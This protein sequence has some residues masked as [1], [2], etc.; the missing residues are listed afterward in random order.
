[1]TLIEQGHEDIDSQIKIWDLQRRSYLIMYYAR[2]KGY[3]NLGLQ[4]LPVLAASEYNGKNAI[5]MTMLLTDIKKS[6]YG[7]EKWTLGETSVETVLA[8]EPKHTFKKNPYIVDVW[9]DND[10]QNTYPYTNW[11]YIYYQDSNG[12]WHKVRGQV[13]YEGLYYVEHTG[14][15]VYYQLF[16]SDAPRFG[17]TG[18]W[19]VHFK[20]HVLYPP[21]TSSSGPQQLYNTADQGPVPIP[22]PREGSNKENVLGQGEAQVSTPPRPRGSRE[23]SPESPRKRQRPDS[24]DGGGGGRRRHRGDRGPREG[25]WPSPEEVGR[26][27]T[28]TP[29]R[30]R[31]RLER[32]QEDAR[33]PPII[34]LKGP[35][36]PLKCWRTRCKKHSSLYKTASSVFKWIG[37]DG[38]SGNRL[39]VAFEN[40]RQRAAFLE[41][42]TIP[43]HCEYTFGSLMS[44]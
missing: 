31:S 11:E 21:V 22:R 18:Q 2:T 37:K 30:H 15:Q 9:F 41:Q 1:M 32:L 4:P 28:T 43:K 16:A 38:Q 42:V 26:R 14:D 20:N 44:L 23:A 33:D 8:T 19:S 39:M 27:H 7:T 13:S 17:H 40:E 5:A 3:R 12:N 35:A 10:N 36:N 25:S 34:L 6:Q 24:T 29:R